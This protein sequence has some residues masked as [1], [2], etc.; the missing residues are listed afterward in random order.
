MKN[1]I[2][3]LI[4]TVMLIAPLF[5]GRQASNIFIIGMILIGLSFLLLTSGCAALLYSPLL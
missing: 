2:I 4:F 3:F 1:I 5:K